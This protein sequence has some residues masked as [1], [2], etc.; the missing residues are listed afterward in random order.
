MMLT[1]QSQVPAL[2]ALGEDFKAYMCVV[3]GLQLTASAPMHTH[4]QHH[5][6]G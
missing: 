5:R 3:H 2:V 6:T 4:T 1:R